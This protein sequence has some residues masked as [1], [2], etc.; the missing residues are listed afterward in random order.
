MLG[1]GLYIVA[2]MLIGT[3][4]GGDTGDALI[5]SGAIFFF[6]LLIC[7]IASQFGVSFLINSRPKRPETKS[8]LL[9]NLGLVGLGILWLGMLGFTCLAVAVVGMNEA[10]LF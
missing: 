6:P 2:C 9:W 3:W 8:N 5:G 10:V 1:T 4:I 7:S